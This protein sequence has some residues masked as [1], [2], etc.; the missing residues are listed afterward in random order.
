MS[1]C[2]VVQILV[3]RGVDPGPVGHPNQ[4]KAY[5]AYVTDGRGYVWIALAPTLQGRIAGF[6]NADHLQIGSV[7][8]LK[9]INRLEPGDTWYL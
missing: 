6:G 4:A 7:A 9:N 5:E 1:A 2:P 3:L 8:K